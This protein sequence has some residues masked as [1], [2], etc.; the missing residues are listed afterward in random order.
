VAA[1]V[2]RRAGLQLIALKKR[3]LNQTAEI[4]L[5]GGVDLNVSRYVAVRPIQLGYE[6]Q[7]SPS[8]EFP[9]P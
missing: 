7:K 4:A 6:W 2:R 3:L 1:E 8:K 9:Q 5:G